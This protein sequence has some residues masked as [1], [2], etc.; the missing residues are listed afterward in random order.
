MYGSI[1]VVRHFLKQHFVPHKGNDYTPHVFREASVA[2]I[3]IVLIVLV[4]SSH[5]SYFTLHNTPQGAAVISSVLVDLTNESRQAHQVPLLQ[6]STLLE[7]SAALKA[8]DM[9]KYGYFAHVSPEGKNPWYWFSTVGYNFSYAGENLAVDFT[10]TTDVENAL[11]NSPTHRANILGTQFTEV[12]IATRDGMYQGKPTT[13][14]V[15]HFGTPIQIAQADT[16]INQSVTVIPK[17]SIKKP[18]KKPVVLGVE[19]T[20][21]IEESPTFIAVENTVPIDEAETIAPAPVAET[22]VPVYAS[23]Y[24]RFLFSQS[25]RVQTILF[26]L[27]IL[28]GLAL[29]MMIFVEFHRQKTKNIIY[30][31]G[32]LVILG[33][34][35]CINSHYISTLVTN[36]S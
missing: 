16:N 2:A 30:G 8:E 27:S 22:Q 25:Q 6:K 36:I 7:S 18:E 29:L 12:G 35:I 15:E 20:R 3:L 24:D 9:V 32:L 11:L 28:I 10:E 13:F 4:V 1:N 19:T 33:F 17:T 23:A 5:R 34:L 26:G 21:T 31:V 14:V